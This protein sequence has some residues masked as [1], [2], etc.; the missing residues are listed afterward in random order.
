MSDTHLEPAASIAF[1]AVGKLFGTHQVLENI[2]A[3]VPRAL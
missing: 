1:R 3:D 2:T